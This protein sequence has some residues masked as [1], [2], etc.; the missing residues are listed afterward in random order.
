MV[1]I[2]RISPPIR[3]PNIKPWANVEPAAAWFQVKTPVPRRIST[4]IAVL[5][6]E[7]WSVITFS[8]VSAR[9]ARRYAASVIAGLAVAMDGFL[10]GLGKLWLSF[11][12]YRGGRGGR[13][14]PGNILLV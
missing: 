2:A 1:I 14:G 5:R 4:R 7:P 3:P 10:F 9:P 8:A 11:D 6:T 12:S 13:R